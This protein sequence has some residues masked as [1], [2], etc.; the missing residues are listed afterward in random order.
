MLLNETV[1]TLMWIC[2]LNCVTLSLTLERGAGPAQCGRLLRGAAKSSRWL[3]WGRVPP[4]QGCPL[5]ALL[6]SRSSVSSLSSSPLPPRVLLK[7]CG[8]GKDNKVSLFLLFCSASL[9]HLLFFFLKINSFA[10][11]PVIRKL[12]NVLVFFS[13]FLKLKLAK[14]ISAQYFFFPAFSHST[15]VLFFFLTEIIGEKLMWRF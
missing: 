12:E 15:K 2:C 5:W 1:A 10:N 13:G 4:R 6:S 11:Y 3:Q 8:E 14:R 9:L 7:S